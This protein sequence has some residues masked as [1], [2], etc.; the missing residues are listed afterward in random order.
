L[1]RSSTL[2]FPSSKDAD[3]WQRAVA[4]MLRKEREVVEVFI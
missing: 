4:Y 3:T 2:Q 1:K